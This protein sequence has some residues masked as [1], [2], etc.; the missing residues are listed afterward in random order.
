MYVFDELIHV[1]DL[2][3]TILRKVVAFPWISMFK[4]V[5]IQYNY[6]KNVYTFKPKKS[7]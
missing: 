5:V 7:Q 4:S 6:A 3:K 1:Y 2:L